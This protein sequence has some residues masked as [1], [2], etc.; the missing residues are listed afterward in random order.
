MARRWRILALL[1]VVRTKMAFQFQAVGAL[2]PA[3]QQSFGVS[4]VDIGLLIGLFFAP[5][6]VISVPG[7]V[8]GGQFG[9]KNIVLIG[10]AFL[11]VGGVMMT[12]SEIWA[13]HR[14][15]R[16]YPPEC[17]HDQDGRRLVLG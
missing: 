13:A 15:D 11:T 4:I 3:F 1:F 10:L 9:A 17:P 6:I 8:L 2:S 5:G 14:R 16:R 12:V 7:G